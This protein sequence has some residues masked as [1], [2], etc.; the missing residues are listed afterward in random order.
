MTYADAMARY[1]SDK[2]DLR[3]G[4]ELIECTDYFKDT[5]FGVFK[6]DYVGAVVMPGGRPSPQAASTPGRS[7]PS[8]A[9]PRASRTS[10]YKEDGE[11]G[12]PVAK[13]LTDTERAGLADA[14]GAQP[15][16]C[17][18]F[19]AGGPS[20]PGPCSARPASRSATAA[21]SST[22]GAWGFLWVVDAPMF[23]PA[24]AAVASGDVALGSA[25]GPP[26]TTPSPRRSRSS[27]TPSTRTPNRRWPTPTTSSATA[28]KSA[29]ARS[30]STS[31][32]SR[33]GVFELMGSPTTRRRTKF[34]FLLEGFA[35]GRRRTA[36]SPSAGTASS[37]CWPASSP[38]A[39]SS[40]SRSP[41]AA[42]TRSPAPRAHHAAAAQGSRRRLQARGQ[43]GG[44]GGRLRGPI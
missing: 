39:T 30:V 6:A 23:E 32:T 36:A 14:V 16:D 29:A 5:T 35:F 44:E 17:I 33:S 28:T 15:G 8:S 21:A 7:G 43:G 10:S 26:F 20:R 18:F 24:A 22:R 42:S 40:P 13:N 37:R 9:A 41:A 1:G 27:S 3:F 11:L 25:S 34:G 31:A 4:Q 19:A 2:P 38:S 12:G